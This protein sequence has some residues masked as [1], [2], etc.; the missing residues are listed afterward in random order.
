MDEEAPRGLLARLQRWWLK[1]VVPNPRSFRRWARVG[2]W[3]RWLLPARLATQIPVV[4]KRPR[5]PE[6][7]DAP[8][9]RRVLVLEGCVQQVAT[10]AVN[11]QL[12][13]LLRSRGIEV[14][15]VADEACC[16][17]LA[18]HLGDRDAAEAVMRRNVDA[19]SPHLDAV[20]AVISTASGC[21]V[22]VKDY[23]RLLAGDADYAERALAL[24]NKVMDASEYLAAAG[25]R[26]EKGRDAGRVAWHAPCSLQHGQQL[27]GQVEALLRGAG[28]DLVPVRNAHLCCGSA[29]TYS[30]LQPEIA[31][32]LKA[33]KLAALT[34]GEPEIIA[35]ANVGCQ[36]HLGGE[37]PIPV[38]H[39][40]ELLR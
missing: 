31:E 28:Y 40:I 39:W 8:L 20:E 14:D 26:W 23:G 10:P 19:L 13:S 35:T 21:G 11:Q 37:S 25:L 2:G 9:D 34:E 18:L 38:V 17:S 15:R 3:F 24:S 22:T 1:A 7:S 30:L 12:G 5:A 4:G 6:V 32:Q 33:D 36:L 27:R 29:G 16:G